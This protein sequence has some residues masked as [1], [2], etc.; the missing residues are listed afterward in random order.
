MPP[1]HKRPLANQPTDSF[2]QGPD[3][4]ANATCTHTCRM[5]LRAIRMFFSVVTTSRPHSRALGRTKMRRRIV[6]PHWGKQLG[7][8]SLHFEARQFF[9]NICF[10]MFAVAFE[11]TMLSTHPLALVV[12]PFKLFIFNSNRALLPSKCCCFA[13]RMTHCILLSKINVPS[14]GT[15]DVACNWSLCSSSARR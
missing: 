3:R 1:V 10:T 11:H 13:Q 8:M 5:S 15:P 2:I 9:F 6:R 14:R 7:R 4:T 12:G